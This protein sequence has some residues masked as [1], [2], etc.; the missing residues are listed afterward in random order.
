MKKV[1]IQIQFLSEE[2]NNELEKS[3]TFSRC[4]SA[5]EREERLDK[6]NK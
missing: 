1:K 3:I 2:L 4:S 6:V 5:K